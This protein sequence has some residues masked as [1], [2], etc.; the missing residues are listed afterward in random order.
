MLLLILQVNTGHK[1]LL[2]VTKGNYYLVSFVYK[3]FFPF[4][5]LNTLAYS[6]H[7]NVIQKLSRPWLLTRCTQGQSKK[8]SL[9]LTNTGHLF[10]GGRA[11][12][13]CWIPRVSYIITHIEALRRSRMCCKRDWQ[14]IINSYSVC[15]MRCQC[16]F[17]VV[18]TQDRQHHKL[19]TKAVVGFFKL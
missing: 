18:V 5:L 2:Y 4:S 15:P 17:Q 13:S 10:E 12:C 1:R 14:T 9:N 3:L 7:L 8:L 6:Y 11:T 19:M 16:H